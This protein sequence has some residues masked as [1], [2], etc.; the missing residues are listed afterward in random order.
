MTSFLLSAKDPDGDGRLLIQARDPFCTRLR[1][2]YGKFGQGITV[3][4]A[5]LLKALGAVEAP[6][7]RRPYFELLRQHPAGHFIVTQEVEQ[8]QSTPSL[9]EAV[10]LLK[11]PKAGELVLVRYAPGGG[12]TPFIVEVETI[13]ETQQVR[14]QRIEAE[15]VAASGPVPTSAAER[16]ASDAC[17]DKSDGMGV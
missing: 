13:P 1:V 17:C 11:D 15:P 2:N 10:A 7:N 8:G 14:F 12:V 9:N 4:R 3:D 16:M 5:A 6:P